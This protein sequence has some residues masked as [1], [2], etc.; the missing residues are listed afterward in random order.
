[1]I[2]IVFQ[3]GRIPNCD[4]PHAGCCFPQRELF[5]GQTLQ[6]KRKFV[7]GSVAESGPLS[8]DVVLSCSWGSWIL[9]STVSFIILWSAESILGQSLRPVW[10]NCDWKQPLENAEDSLASSFISLTTPVPPGGLSSKGFI[11]SSSL[12]AIKK[13]ILNRTPPRF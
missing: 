7:L 10:K 13:Q 2:D 12:P 9:G 3:T 6:G 4:R 5:E 8:P 1:M 11:H